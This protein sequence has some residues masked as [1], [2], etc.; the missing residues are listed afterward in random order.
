[1]LSFVQRNRVLCAIVVT[2]QKGCDAMK[3]LYYLRGRKYRVRDDEHICKAYL[4]RR[5]L[6][7]LGTCMYVSHK[8]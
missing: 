4:K 7:Q 5:V 2:V 6:E 3:N 1:V 8:K